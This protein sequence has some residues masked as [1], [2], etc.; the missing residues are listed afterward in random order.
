MGVFSMSGFM[1][2]FNPIY[3]GGCELKSPALHISGYARNNVSYI[4]YNESFHDYFNE[5]AP[6]GT[7][8]ISYFVVSLMIGYNYSHYDLEITMWLPRLFNLSYLAPLGI[9]GV[10]IGDAW[11]QKKTYNISEYGLEIN[12]RVEIQ[13]TLNSSNTGGW[14]GILGYTYDREY[15]SIGMFDY[16]IWHTQLRIIPEGTGI[17]DYVGAVRDHY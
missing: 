4:T 5:S 12:E 8:N 9:H 14:V 3:D 10:I 15:E 1:F 17:P 16:A 13:Q 2:I 7:G 6:V 11:G